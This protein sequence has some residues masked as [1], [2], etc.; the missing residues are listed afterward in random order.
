[1]SARGRSQQ[2]QAL[3][4]FAELAF[5]ECHRSLGA[6]NRAVQPRMR[7]RLNEMRGDLQMASSFARSSGVPFSYGNCRMQISSHMS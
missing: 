3:G 2:F 6:K 5:G 1:M 4:R 7:L